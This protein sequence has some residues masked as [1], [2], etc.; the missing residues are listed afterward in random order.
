MFF[1]IF[2]SFAHKP[3][4]VLKA[5]KTFGHHVLISSVAALPDWIYGI[6]EPN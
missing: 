6:R 4:A 1:N 3:S 2:N 5:G